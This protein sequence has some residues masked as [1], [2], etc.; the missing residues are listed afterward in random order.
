MPS[1]FLF[2][3]NGEYILFIWKFYPSLHFHRAKSLMLTF[4]SVFCLQLACC[5]GSAAC[6]C[7]CNCCPKIKQST[8]TRVMYAFYFLLVTIICVIMMSPTVEEMMKDHVSSV[9]DVS[10]SPCKL[11]LVASEFW[12]I[13]DGVF[14]WATSLKEKKK[15]PCDM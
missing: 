9:R 2:E 3:R 14:W 5:C 12:P 4:L 10:A 15:L 13:V 7:C 6:S 1:M 8:G 11:W